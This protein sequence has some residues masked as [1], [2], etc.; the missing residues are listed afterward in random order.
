MFM[1]LIYL[2]ANGCAVK[3]NS[4]NGIYGNDASIFI[5]SSLIEKSGQ[6]G[7]KTEYYTPLHVKNS[8]IRRNNGHGIYTSQATSGDIVT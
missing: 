7:I 2:E 4:L 8:L 6:N 3:N 1:T 5:A